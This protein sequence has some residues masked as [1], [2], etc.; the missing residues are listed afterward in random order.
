[1]AQL[2]GEVF[3]ADKPVSRFLV[4]M[5]MAHN[6]IENAMWKAG[7]ANES[8]RS[9]F[10]Y[11]VLLVMGH[12]VEAADALQHWR[13]CSTEVREFLDALPMDG[14][15]HLKDVGGTLSRVGENAVDHARNHTFHYP[16]PDERYESDAE[17]MKALGALA[18]EPIEIDE[19]EGRPG[20]PRYVFADKAAAM[21]AM[22][23]HDL[24]DEEAYR[25][26]VVELQ[27]GAV[28]F[29]KFVDAAFQKAMDD[30]YTE[31]D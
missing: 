12:F 22:G 5:A 10:T 28:A 19:I 31:S 27:A 8:D 26:Q 14:K 15:Q 7:E 25:A 2:V 29:V 9:D 11:W 18:D 24:E 4:S 1:M 13:R 23:R 17:L 20:R 6:D 21:V 30:A 3:P 16:T